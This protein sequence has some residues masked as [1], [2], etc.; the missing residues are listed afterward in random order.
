MDLAPGQSLGQYR[1]IDKIGE[2]GMGAVYKADQPSI[3]RTV[4]IK[5]LS[6]AFAE[7]AD[8]RERF[9][10]ELD[11]ITRL[12]HPHILPVY[13]FGELDGSPYIVMRFMTGGS[14]QDRLQRSSFDRNEAVRLLEQLAL[15][16]D[17]AH[18]RGIVHRD[19]KPANVLLDESGNAYLADFG[20]AKSVGGTRDLTATGSVL[21][22]PAYMSP[23]QARGDK[24][25]RRSD[26]Y[27]F[28]V[29]IY[30]ALSGH[31]P[32]DANDAWGFITK[33]INE[34]PIP[35]RQFAPDLPPAVEDV[36][37]NGLAKD[38]EARPARATD[39]IAAVRQ[40]M[41]APAGERQAIAPGSTRAGA[42][43]SVATPS[44]TIIG[45]APT[46]VA[47]P[48]PA[49]HRARPGWSLAVI[50]ASIVFGLLVVG[51]LLAGVLYL[52]RDRLFGP[53][54]FTY[55][56]GDSPR[57][58]LLSGKA[59]WVANF[60]GNSVTK[61]AASGCG[62]AQDSCGGSLGTYS[63][64]DLPVALAFDGQ[65]LWAASSLKQTLSILDPDTGQ[66]V[67]RH[68]IPHVPSALIWADSFLWTANAIAGT[69]TKVSPD[70][71][72]EA[73]TP[74]GKGPLALA[75]DGSSL[76]I[77]NKEGK[78]LVRMDPATAQVAPPIGLAG[79]PLALIFDGRWLW[80]ALGDVGQ[81]IQID[82]KTGA[83][84]ERVDTRADPSAL[85]FDGESLW[86]AAPKA[87]KIFR[88]NPTGAQVTQTITVAGTPIAL[89]SLP[90]GTGC[91]DL[92][93]AV[94]S[95]DAVSRIRVQ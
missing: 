92:W 64:D 57:A 73:D 8:A 1:I 51:G 22:S 39:L 78:S 17:F 60:F 49:T 82:P 4:V 44:R 7:Y 47:S 31:L 20:L 89:Q 18:D 23:E 77:A 58:L 69:V 87:G 61:L 63:V 46:T 66:V 45:P 28:A 21:G 38:R 2:G 25:D 34:A 75:F 30:Q 35:I 79:E 72:V 48:L 88:I 50:L 16:L 54:V 86:A 40:A 11:M 74:V 14:L 43:A 19:L 36:L 37:A 85:T 42:T 33:H 26:G 24:L 5:V 83:V 70:G 59:L 12:E 29:L 6:G 53:R 9:R 55:P 27:S 93:T 15:A 76:W 32:F 67:A 90:C 80:V 91:W 10:R 68:T 52:G 81:V 3:P 13:D 84:G 94:E 62:A 95:A 71:Q 56:V 65:H 41:S